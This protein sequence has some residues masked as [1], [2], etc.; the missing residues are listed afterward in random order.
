MLPPACVLILHKLA[1][2]YE[3]AR[4]F[5]TLLTRGIIHPNSSLGIVLLSAE[6]MVASVGFLLGAVLTGTIVTGWRS[7]ETFAPDQ[8]YIV[9]RYYGVGGCV[10]FLV[11]VC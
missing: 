8:Q 11:L 4:W 1:D 6:S 10:C 9:E 2:R 5:A 3:V 7:H